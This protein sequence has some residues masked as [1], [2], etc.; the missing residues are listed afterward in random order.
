EHGSGKSWTANR[1]RDLVDP[2][3]AASRAEPRE[4]RDLVIAARNSWILSLDNVSSLP[5]WLS[6]GLCRL[7]TGSGFA[8]RELFTDEDEVLFTATRPMIVNGIGDVVTRSDLLDRSLLVT[9]QPIP[10]ERRRDERELLRGFA[11]VRPRVLGALL[12]AV[13]AALRDRDRITLNRAPR[14]ADFA[15]WAA[16]AESALGWAAGTF[17]AAYAASRGEAHELALDGSPVAVA[18]RGLLAE[19]E[20]WQGTAA[21]LL[22]ALGGRVAESV[23]R[24]RDWPGTGRGLSSALRRVAPNLRA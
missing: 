18:V 6:D 10:D 21:E 7:A 11:D 15:H 12:D 9:L 17:A 1:L 3:E 19:V 5:G 20:T 24:G 16:A 14:M 4:P 23:R 13:S 22:G 2:N 8:T